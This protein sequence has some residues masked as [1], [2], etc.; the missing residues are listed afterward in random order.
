MSCRLLH[1]RVLGPRIH[2]PQIFAALAG[3][4]D[5]PV[6]RLLA[7]A[8]TSGSRRHALAVGIVLGAGPRD[9][10]WKHAKFVTEA[11]RAAE[12]LGEDCVRAIVGGLHSAAMRGVRMGTPGQP[13]QE[14]IEQRDKATER[15]QAL[16][17]SSIEHQF[18][19]SLAATAE[20]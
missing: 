3:L 5:E 17:H 16:P 13:Y 4:Y 2:G 12:M 14:D 11:L 20:S 18:Y 1:F 7:E 10:A 15:A 8:V 9:F 19:R 6:L